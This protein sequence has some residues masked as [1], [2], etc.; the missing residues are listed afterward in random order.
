[1]GTALKVLMSYGIGLL[2]ATMV[3]YSYHKNAMVIAQVLKGTMSPW[4]LL[5]Q[6]AMGFGY[7]SCWYTGF[8]AAESG[9]WSTTRALLSLA[10]SAVL[11]VVLVVGLQVRDYGKGFGEAF[12]NFSMEWGLGT[13]MWLITA[14]AIYNITKKSEPHVMN[15]VPAAESPKQVK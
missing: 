4:W 8:F 5:L 1:M 15:P 7:G 14:A 13:F 12:K 11:V 3:D 9:P 6:A 10:G 2:L